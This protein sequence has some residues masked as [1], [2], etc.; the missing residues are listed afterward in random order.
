MSEIRIYLLY[1]HISISAGFPAGPQVYAPLLSK[2]SLF[3]HRKTPVSKK[4]DPANGSSQTV[5][6]A[7]IK[8]MIYIVSRSYAYMFFPYATSYTA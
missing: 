1:L 6:K 3:H 8:R 7:R 4:D 5:E 2:A